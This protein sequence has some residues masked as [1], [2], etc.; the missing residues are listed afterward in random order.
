MFPVLFE[1]PDWV[2]V[3]GGQP[4]TSFGLMMFLAFLAAGLVHRS[5]TKRLGGDPDTTWDLLFMAVIGGIVGAKLYYMLLNFPR[6][7]EDPLGLIPLPDKTGTGFNT[8]PFS[9]FT[10]GIEFLH[11][12][13][14][15]IHRALKSF[16]LSL[17]IFRT[18]DAERRK[19][20][21][22]DLISAI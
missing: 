22:N 6:L 21:P 4:V 20:F 7:I 15:S 8:N 17:C 12:Y 16:H 14:L 1:F 5:E 11:V 9:V 10:I 18:Q 2:P 19:V 3:L 13:G